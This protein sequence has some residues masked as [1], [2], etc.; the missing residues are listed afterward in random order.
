MSLERK[1]DHDHEAWME[2]KELSPIEEDDMYGEE[3][4]DGAVEKLKRA[5]YP[6]YRK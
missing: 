1:D 6:Y 4:T 5:V 2:S 3:I